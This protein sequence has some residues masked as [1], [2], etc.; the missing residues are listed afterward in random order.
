MKTGGCCCCFYMSED[1]GAQAAA[2]EGGMDEDGADF[3]CV[4][5]GIEEFRFADVGVVAAEEG[6]AFGPSP[7]ACKEDLTVRTCGFNEEIGFVADQLRVEA[8]DCAQ[9]AF[10]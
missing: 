10:N 3:G 5:C 6:F 8:E 2:G 4:D 1:Q 9:G 7:A